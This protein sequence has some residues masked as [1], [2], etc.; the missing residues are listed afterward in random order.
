MDSLHTRPFESTKI[1]KGITFPGFVSFRQLLITGPP[2]A[3]KSTI[4]R[5]LGGWSEEGYIDL[6]LKNWWTAQSLSLRP[7]EIHLGFPFKG[8]KEALTVFD[9]A[10][11]DAS[12]PLEIDFERIVL[13]PP[14]RF[15]FSVNW[16][17]RYVFEFILPEPGALLRQRIKRAKLGTHHVDEAVNLERI[18]RQLSVYR[19]VA[20]HL[21]QQGISI[22]I[23]EGT[24]GGPLQI[25]D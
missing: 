24:E 12:P 10:W 6:S 11:I 5:K 2:G 3:G 16:K 1:I 13:P 23:R 22:Y 17:E 8:A 25:I 9:K 15:F 20:K 19:Q 18:K 14:K 21:H 4:I 7:R